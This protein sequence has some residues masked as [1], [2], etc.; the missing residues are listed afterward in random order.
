MAWPGALASCYILHSAI[1]S[2]DIDNLLDKQTNKQT[3]K[4][5]LF[6]QLL[7]VL[8]T[9]YV[10]LIVDLIK[11][12]T[13]NILENINDSDNNDDNNDDDNNNNN[14]N[15]NNRNNNNNNNNN[16]TVYIVLPL[17]KR[18]PTKTNKQTK[19]LPLR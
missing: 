3:N 7:F 15:K 12:K 16:N 19:R 9:S 4:N 18:F 1:T 11:Y 2:S 13:N 8:T 10:F 6:K 5:T 14:N 17:F